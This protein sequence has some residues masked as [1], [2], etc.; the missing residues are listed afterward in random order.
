MA[1]ATRD[2]KVH[3]ILT[4]DEA[5][6]LYIHLNPK[7]NPNRCHII[8]QAIEKALGYKPQEAPDL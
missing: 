2:L 6:D 7:Y 3:L 4:E 1:Q 8:K 5:R